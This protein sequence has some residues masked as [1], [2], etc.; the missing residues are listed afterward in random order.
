M[1]LVDSEVGSVFLR[2]VNG[3]IGAT[4]IDTAPDSS[5]TGCVSATSAQHS[6]PRAGSAVTEKLAR[7]GVPRSFLINTQWPTPN[8][9]S[10][11]GGKQPFALLDS[12]YQGRT[13]CFETPAPLTTPHQRMSLLSTS[14]LTSL[15]CAPAAAEQL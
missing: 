1:W 5:A 15:D 9:F 8:P 10:K 7:G 3:P 11:A 12:S 6:G 13:Y 2:Q 14:S 4:P